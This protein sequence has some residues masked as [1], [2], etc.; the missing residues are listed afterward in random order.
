VQMIGGLS[1]VHLGEEQPT[2]PDAATMTTLKQA[3]EEWTSSAAAISQHTPKESQDIM[4]QMRTAMNTAKLAIDEY[5]KNP[6]AA[7]LWQAQRNLLQ[8]ILAEKELLSS[9]SA[10]GSA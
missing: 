3:H 8:F 9:L 7:M 10:P 1:L 5:E 2:P 4:Q 6:A